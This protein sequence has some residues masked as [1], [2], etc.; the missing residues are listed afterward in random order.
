M[1]NLRYT[2]LIMQKICANDWCKT[3]FEITQ[4]DLDFYE[5]ISSVF[6]GKKEMI[7]PPTKC[8]ECRFQRRMVWRREHA[9]IGRTCSDCKRHIISVHSEDAPYPVYCLKCWWSDRW[10]P[11]SFGR[12]VDLERPFMEQFGELLRVVPQIAMMNDEGVASENCEYCQDFAFGK[13]CYLIT[14]A[15]ELQDCYYCDYNCLKSRLLFDCSSTHF[16]EMAYGCMA[17]QRLFRCAFL[18][19][20]ESCSD[21]LFGIELKG[22]K[23]CIGCIGLRQK[24][25]C[26]FNQQYS[27]GEYHYQLAALHLDSHNGIEVMKKRFEHW[28]LA[29]PR[30]YAHLEHCENCLGDD[31]FN[32]KDTLGFQ[33]DGAEYCKFII[34]GDSPKNCYDVSQTGR[35]EWCCEGCTPDHSYMTHF[36]TWCWKDKYV[37]YSDNCHNSQHLFGC[38]GVKRRQYCILNKQYTKD[39]YERLV[40][41]IIDRMRKDGEW[42]EFFP[43][44][45]SPYCYNETNAQESFSLTREEALRRGLKWRDT[46]P[47]LL[48]PQTYRI[49]D[50]IQ[51]VP[52]TILDEVLACE[53]CGKNYKILAQ[54]LAFYRDMSLPIPHSCYECRYAERLRYRNP[55]RLWTRPCMQC[56]K[57]METTYAPERPEIVYCENCYLKEVY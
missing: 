49:P 18:R 34:H 40:G 29:F 15:W 37:L 54:E 14:G 12:D 1:T 57:E 9:L 8:P 43:M 32:C 51:N 44:S 55:R 25:F 41:R 27:K 46:N 35:C 20:C 11:T 47:K 28:I 5:K 30:K 13:N 7:P 52:D 45:L 6:A 21:C 2:F 56:G 36:T 4:D 17:S 19:H 42:G 24:E 38:I 23:N 48:K 33:E 31:L 26:I 3:S 16:S 10:D 39:A 53:R 50:A 22:C